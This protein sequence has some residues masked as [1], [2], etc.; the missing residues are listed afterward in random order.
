MTLGGCF[1]LALDVKGTLWAWGTN[2]SGELGL[3]DFEPRAFP[4]P[5]LGI[6]DKSIDFFACGTA[7][8]VLLA[9]YAPRQAE[10]IESLPS[11]GTIKHG[12]V[13]VDKRPVNTEKSIL[14][15]TVT[16]GGS[17]QKSTA[18]LLEVIK[19]ERD[20][21][22]S[23]L[24]AE[25]EEKHKAEQ[26]ASELRVQVRTLMAESEK[27]KEEIVH[28]EEL[29]KIQEAKEKLEHNNM[30]LRKDLAEQ[31][32][33]VAKYALELELSQKDFE[34]FKHKSHTELDRHLE[35]IKDLKRLNTHVQCTFVPCQQLNERME[36]LHNA[37]LKQ[38]EEISDL[39]KTV[40]ETKAYYEDKIATLLK[41]NSELDT[42]A[43]LAFSE[44]FFVAIIIINRV[45]KYKEE[46]ESLSNS[47][48][49]LATNYRD[50]KTKREQ[51]EQ[52]A[53]TLIK[54]SEAKGVR[55][56]EL[57]KER[58]RLMHE[59]EKALADNNKF[60]EMFHK[61]NME[62]PKITITPQYA[63]EV[64]KVPVLTPSHVTGK[65]KMFSN[66]SEISNSLRSSINERSGSVATR[67]KSFIN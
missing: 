22:E 66:R 50:E 53:D 20:Y 47:L 16:E 63:Q 57:T 49:E 35:E 58:I 11:I 9:N 19:K 64:P 41:E 27:M 59:L 33:K 3:G 60:L 61:S 10:A 8:V 4:Y 43:T 23:S 1:G 44:Q 40:Q 46:V 29:A 17:K 54:E 55:I 39:H 18:K 13:I 30:M 21:F 32:E 28:S 56:E 37:K 7:F 14:F 31:E 6:E 24:E 48:Q 15:E 25:R 42:R 62:R 5:V 26:E 67:C 36:E 12:N 51:L 34:L 38:T 52:N 65:E 45:K 2:T